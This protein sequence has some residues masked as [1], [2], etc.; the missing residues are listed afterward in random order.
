MFKQ[1][2]R[3]AVDSS[4]NIVKRLRAGL[5]AHISVEKKP[6]TTW[7]NARIRDSDCVCETTVVNDDDRMELTELESTIDDLFN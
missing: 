1:T 3:N 2:K 6:L 7:W 5:C 4:V